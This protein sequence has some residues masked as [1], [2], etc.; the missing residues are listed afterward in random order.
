MATAEASPVS[1]FPAALTASPD[2]LSGHSVSGIASHPQQHG[3]FL[4]RAALAIASPGAQP[5]KM[6]G[7]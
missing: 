5:T 2:H 7:G 1:R 6:V 3:Q 4:A